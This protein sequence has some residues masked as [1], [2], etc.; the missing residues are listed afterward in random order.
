MLNGLNLG[1]KIIIGVK[2]DGIGHFGLCQYVPRS[3][4][5]VTFVRPDGLPINL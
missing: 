1:A 5:D 3:L 2:N 4:I